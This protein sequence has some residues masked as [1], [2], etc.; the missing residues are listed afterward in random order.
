MKSGEVSIP[1]T[2]FIHLKQ[3]V[4]TSSG[5]NEKR[6]TVLS[7]FERMKGAGREFD[8]SAGTAQAMKRYENEVRARARLGFTSAHSSVK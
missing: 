8:G 2:A 1:T 4:D 7:T 3:G 6:R 5:I